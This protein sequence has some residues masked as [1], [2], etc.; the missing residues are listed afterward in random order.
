[1]MGFILAAKL[2]FL[3]KNFKISKLKVVKLIKNN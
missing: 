1:M 2:F 3:K